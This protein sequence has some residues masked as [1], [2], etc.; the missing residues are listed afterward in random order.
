MV[1]LYM[2]ALFTAGVKPTSLIPALLLL[3]LS[4]ISFYQMDV[5]WGGIGIGSFLLCLY[6]IMRSRR[7]IIPTILIVLILI[8]LSLHA[9]G[10]LSYRPLLFTISK[11]SSP[12]AISVLGIMVAINLIFYT[13]VRMN[14]PFII[15]FV[16]L[17]AM[18][19]E[20]LWVLGEYISDSF[21]GTNL[22]SSNYDL[23][24]DMICSFIGSLL[25]GFIL[26]L[27]MI[28]KAWAREY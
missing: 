4:A 23:M 25:G 22:I 1:N 18:G 17:F 7:Q 14:G 3:V 5:F 26:Y 10:S 24:V 21:L 13:E 27:L 12:I 2:V 20:N 6:P 16:I 11:F 28:R 9:V 15:F 19:V 8:P